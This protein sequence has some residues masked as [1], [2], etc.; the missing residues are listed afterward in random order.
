MR[1]F[2]LTA[3]GR[4]GAAAVIV[5][6]E[7][8]A[9][10]YESD[11]SFID[12]VS[13]IAKEAHAAVLT[14]VVARTA[15]REPLNSALLVDADGN[16]VSRY[17]KVNLVPFGEF[18]PWPF[19]LVTQ[20]VSTE[21]GDFAPGKR[22]VV[23]SLGA[24]K[25]GTFICYESAFPNYIRQVHGG[26]CAG[27]FQYFEGQLVW[28]DG[29]TI[30]AFAAGADARGGERQVDR[31][32]HQRRNFRRSSIRRVVWGSRYP[33]TRKRRRACS[34]TT[35][36]TRR[37]THGTATGLCCCAGWSR[38]PRL[39]APCCRKVPMSKEEHQPALEF[40]R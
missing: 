11:R 5:W 26:G 33:N 2:S 30:S 3:S 15:S 34:S 31:A 32:L 13:S 4:N 17:D 12:L 18:V 36:A 35:S 19:G 20:K 25:I 6:P 23:S 22:V 7:V 29:S 21:A 9:P 10:F 16:R 37:F 24:H 14:G 1:L 40:L 38:S 8:P 27:A 39:Q 28:Q